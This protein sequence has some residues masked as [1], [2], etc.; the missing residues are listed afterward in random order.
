MSSNHRQ[1]DVNTLYLLLL[2]LVRDDPTPEMIRI[3]N[4]RAKKWLAMLDD[5]DEFVKNNPK[6]L[7]TR[8]E[9]GIPDNLRFA[10]INFYACGTLI[11]EANQHTC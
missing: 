2:K 10:F 9:K 1:R 4:E 6:K 8:L 3:E 7:K 5:W 11:S